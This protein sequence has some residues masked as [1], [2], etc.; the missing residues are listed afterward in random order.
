MMTTL[1]QG[2]AYTDIEFQQQRRIIATGI[3]HG[4]DG[5]TLVDPGPTTCLAALRRQL[6]VSGMQL[7]DV[8][9]LFITHIHLDHAG[10][11]G[12]LLRENPRVRVYVHESG[13]PH[14]VDPSR[15]LASATRLYGDAM[16][17]LWGE[18][19]PV[20]ASA[21]EPLAGGER[22]S[23]GGRTWEVAYT[24]G[25][26]SHHVSYF[27]DA[28][29]VAF[30][31]D[32]AGVQVLSGG[33]VLP[34]TPPPDIHLPHWFASLARIQAWRPRALF[35]T[36]FGPTEHI[37]PHM[38]ELSDHL[39]LCERLAREALARDTDDASRE[40]WFT[41]QVR[42][43]MLRRMSEADVQAYAMAG[44]FDLNWRGLV[45]YLTKVAGSRE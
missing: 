13:A 22:V 43:E 11:A 36:H 41:E 5:V 12:T 38:A 25:H 26:A 10:V 17:R 2:L 33:V 31:G 6:A 42:R 35:M 34:P 19:A 45:R 9:A 32:T 18:V 29:G 27:D 23:R 7:S 24:P 16:D 44:R 20:P 4:V 1:A 8:T 40:A 30:V 39:R 28:S 21:I 15:L 14:L 3:V 37:G